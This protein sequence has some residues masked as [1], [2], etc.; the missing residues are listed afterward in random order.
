MNKEA[1]VYLEL[2]VGSN[3]FKNAYQDTAQSYKAHM[4]KFKRTT[5]DTCRLRY[6]KEEAAK[7]ILYECE[8]IAGLI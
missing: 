6:A 1:Q 2:I 4:P 8:T 5:H 3:P 7:Y